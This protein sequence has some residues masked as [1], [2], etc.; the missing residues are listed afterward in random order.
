MTSHTTKI[1][2]EVGSSLLTALLM[3]RSHW[4]GSKAR[5]LLHTVALFNEK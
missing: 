5:G 2:S 3:L 1:A 4:H